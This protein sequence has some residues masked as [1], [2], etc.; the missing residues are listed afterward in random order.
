MAEEKEGS[1]FYSSFYT[2]VKDIDNFEVHA[3]FKFISET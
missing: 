2:S 3:L 1:R